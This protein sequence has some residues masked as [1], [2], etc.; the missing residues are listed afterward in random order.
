MVL[1]VMWDASENETRADHDGKVVFVDRRACE[2]LGLM[3][4]QVRAY[5]S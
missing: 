3:T 5:M 2:I 4:S 1:F